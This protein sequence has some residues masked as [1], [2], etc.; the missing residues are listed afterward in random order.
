MPWAYTIARRLL[1][2]TVR[3]RH[4]EARVVIDCNTIETTVPFD[5]VAARQ[6]ADRLDAR[7]AALPSTH[8]DAFDLVKCDGLSLREAADV[9]GTTVLA[10]K[11]RL[12]RACKAL[13]DVLAI[14]ADAAG[15]GRS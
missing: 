9:L 11:L 14:D 7:L 1:I 3:R 5:A 10:V 12:H 8:R 15:A 13:R 2:D 6:T 4:C